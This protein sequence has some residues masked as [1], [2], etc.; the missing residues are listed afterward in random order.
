MARAT[1]ASHDGGDLPDLFAAERRLR[2]S[3]C[4]RIAG[5][6]EAGRGCLAGPVVAAAVI[7]PASS[8]LA[9][10][11]DSKTL[12]ARTREELCDQILDAALCVGIGVSSAAL[13]DC[14]NILRATHLAMRSAVGAL[15]PL[16]DHVLVDGLPVDCLGAHCEAVVDGDRLCYCIAAAS[17]V[18]KVHRDRIMERLDEVY[19][20]YGFARHMGYGT[21]EHLAALERLGPCPV[22]R[23]SFS[24]LRQ[25]RLEL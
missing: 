25:G 21:R 6:D 13:I 4:V 14:V 5:V 10:I 15:Q 24:P 9:G 11:A 17:I 3:G 12:S 19:P 8:R 20:G 22:H 1:A 23:M 2:R 16:A 7:L 18:A